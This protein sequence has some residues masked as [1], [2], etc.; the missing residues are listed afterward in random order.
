MTEKEWLQREWWSM[1][2]R[3]VDRIEYNLSDMTENIGKIPVSAYTCPE[4]FNA[5]RQVLFGRVPLLAGLSPEL[6][7]SG[8]VI[9]FDG[10]GPGI[11]I[12]R[13]EDGGLNA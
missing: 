12:S 6:S 5:E 9:L 1:R 7:T 10:A 13:R 2:R 8:Q 11:I 4:R 3:L